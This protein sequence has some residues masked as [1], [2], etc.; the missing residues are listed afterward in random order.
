MPGAVE[1]LKTMERLSGAQLITLGNNEPVE[2]GMALEPSA[3]LTQIWNLPDTSERNAI[4]VPSGENMGVMS[5]P[6]VRITGFHRNDDGVEVLSAY[7]QM[8]RSGR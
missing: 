3:R 1:E 4:A 8:L 6:G 7:D 5:W 2:T